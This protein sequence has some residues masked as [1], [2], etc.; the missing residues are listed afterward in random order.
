MLGVSFHGDKEL[1]LWRALCLLP[2][3]FQYA[4]ISIRKADQWPA[5]MVFYITACIT[6]GATLVFYAAVF[7]RLARYIPHVRKARDEELEEGNI[8][9][10]EY[11]KIESLE[12][13]HVSSISTAYSN[14]RYLLTLV[15][16]LSV[17]LP[18]QGN[19]FGNNLA[20]CLTNPYRVVLG[21]WWFIFRKSS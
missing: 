20:L 5:A 15:I 7:P 14:I 4:M 10:A 3:I 17:L 21:I 2:T 16:N 9:Q 8:S 11:D 6:Y 13:N 19:P 12:R 1:D 18:L